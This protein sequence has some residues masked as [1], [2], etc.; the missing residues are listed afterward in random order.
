[1]AEF[2]TNI[3]EET[4]KAAFTSPTAQTWFNSEELLEKAIYRYLRQK[5]EKKLRELAAAY[6]ADIRAE[7]EKE[8]IS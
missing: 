6:A 5:T 3:D 2:L 7:V 4:I 1:M 8:E